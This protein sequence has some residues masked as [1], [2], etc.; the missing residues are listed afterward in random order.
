MYCLQVSSRVNAEIVERLLTSCSSVRIVQVQT[1]MKAITVTRLEDITALII[2]SWAMS[3]TTALNLRTR[4]PDTTIINQVTIITVIATEKTMAHKMSYLHLQPR[5][6][7][8][9]TIF[10]S[11]IVE[12]VGIIL[13]LKRVG[14][15]LKVL[16]RVSLWVTAKV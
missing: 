8:L 16:M 11:V 7:S 2:G 13:T 9:Q 12:P 10:G 5:L 6:R 1:I 14:S 4:I 3:S 15:M